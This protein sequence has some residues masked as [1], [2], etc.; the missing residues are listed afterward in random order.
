M[1]TR[2]EGS[3]KEATRGLLTGPLATCSLACNQCP[4]GRREPAPTPH[5]A[6]AVLEAT[7]AGW[8]LIPGL[9]TFR[10]LGLLPSDLA[11]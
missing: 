7:P 1:V 3:R 9:E 6:Y 8:C 10:P 11:C 4:G 5:R 2:M